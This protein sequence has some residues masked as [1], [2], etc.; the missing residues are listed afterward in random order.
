METTQLQSRKQ[1]LVAISV[2]I[3]VLFQLYLASNT[4]LNPTQVNSKNWLSQVQGE[5]VLLCTA[6]GFKWVDI[7]TLVIEN[8][9]ASSEFMQSLHLHE[10]VQFECPLLQAVQFFL[11]CSIAIYL[12]TI[13]WS[14]RL[15]NALIQYHFAQCGKWV[16]KHIAPKQSPPCLFPA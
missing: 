6:D 8:S 9:I 5:Q 10:N 1:R 4:V 11:L 13:H 3:A 12:S 2:I 15:N 14:R 7:N 16:Y